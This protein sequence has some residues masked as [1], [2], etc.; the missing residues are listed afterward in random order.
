MRSYV[1]RR[2]LQAVPLLFGISI[3]LFVALQM[4][5]GGPLALAEDVQGRVTAE[6]L[7]RLRN[8]YGL[9]D[10]LYVQYHRWVGDLLRGDWGTSFNTG[11]PVLQTIAE[12]VPTTLLLTGTAFLVTLLL[13]F[14][15]G[16]LAAVRQYSVFDYVSTSV[17]FLGVSIPS[18]WFGLVL[19]YVF[20][21]SLGW[22]PS[23]GG[24]MLYEAQTVVIHDGHWWRGFFPGFMIFLCILSVNFVGDGLRDVFDPSTVHRRREES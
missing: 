21:F 1:L 18:F 15:I 3:L 19:L 7:Q 22:L 24:R 6:D 23:V 17:A 4:T 14:P 13:S 12:R 9:D 2:L 10:P 8:R 20:T 11:R 5:P 16:L